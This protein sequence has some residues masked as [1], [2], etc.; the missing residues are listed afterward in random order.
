MGDKPVIVV[1]TN[2]LVNLAT[3][4]V[5]S[6]AGAPT[7][8]DPLKTVLSVYDVHIP[9]SVLG[10]VSEAAGDD[11]LLGT[12]ADLVLMA[13]QSLTTHDVDAKIEDALAYGLDRGESHAIWLT[14]ELAAE[15]FVTDEF[16][17]TNYLIVS[18]ALDD[19]NTL[20]TTPH[21]LCVLVQ[22]EILPSP[23]VAAALTYYV[24]IKDWDEQ[25]IDRLRAEYL[26]V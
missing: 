13:A 9:S 2:V 1:D 4:V 7:G 5:D 23:Y 26:S 21:L 18:I 19:R 3:P 8:E 15:M 6:R 20:F 22:R 12:A 10:E 24:E 16:N 17:T 14:N 11:D 25:Y